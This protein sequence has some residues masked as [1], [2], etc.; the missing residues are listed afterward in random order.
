MELVSYFLF[1]QEQIKERNPVLPNMFEI[2]SVKLKGLL[3]TDYGRQDYG[4]ASRSMRSGRGETPR[5]MSGERNPVSVRV[6]RKAS[7]CC[8]APAPEAHRASNQVD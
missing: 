3:T 1:L 4:L 5:E 6:L 2:V 8:T 7:A